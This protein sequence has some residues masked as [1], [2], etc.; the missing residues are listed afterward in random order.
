MKVYASSI[1]LPKHLPKGSIKVIVKNND[2]N[3]IVYHHQTVGNILGSNIWDTFIYQTNPDFPIPETNKVEERE[4][5]VDNWL[6]FE[7]YVYLRVINL[8]TQQE[9]ENLDPAVTDGL[10]S[11]RT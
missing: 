1:E 5:T 10:W 11:R 7:E 6:D 9:I 2:D 8:N 4:G 3:V